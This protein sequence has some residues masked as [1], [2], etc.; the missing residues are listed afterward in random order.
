M[1]TLGCAFAGALVVLL[2]LP[3][4]SRLPG[5][6]HPRDE[7]VPPGAAVPVAESHRAA[8]HRVPAAVH[9]VPAAVLADLV[10]GVLAAGL[11]A[12]VALAAVRR[13]AGGVEPGGLAA[14]EQA[15]QLAVATGLAPGDLVR[16]AA[17]EQRRDRA[18]AQIRAARRLGVLVLLPV[19][20][21]LLPAFV[22]LTVVPLVLT[23]LGRTVG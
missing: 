1:L 15:L 13:H 18:A 19:G 9:R 16:A 22:A 17:A 8:V 6:G 4:R 21:C 11:P 10:A 23:L 20:L 5:P 2:W 7:R 3:G 14:V 12:D